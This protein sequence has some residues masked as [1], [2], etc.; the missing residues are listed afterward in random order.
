[1]DYIIALLD[2]FRISSPEAEKLKETIDNSEISFKSNLSREQKRQ[3][4]GI[5]DMENHLIEEIE[6]QAF[7]AG[8]R[9]ADG[10]HRELDTIPQF[11]IVR[12]DEE[13]LRPPL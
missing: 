7:I 10:I 8:Y 13:Q 2:R 12:E 3:L 4:L 9:L 5:R 6:L 11:S 1:M